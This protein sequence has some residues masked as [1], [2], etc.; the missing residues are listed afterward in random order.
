MA[1]RTEAVEPL[2]LVLTKGEIPNRGTAANALEQLGW[3]P[4]NEQEAVY[5]SIAKAE[6]SS[7]VMH[8][9]AAVEPVLELL[10]SAN[11][12]HRADAARSLGEI[13]DLRVVASLVAFGARQN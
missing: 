6:W 4:G 1:G 5:L 7:E 2:L 8:S 12:H 10:Q 11:H 3:R 13:G 9:S